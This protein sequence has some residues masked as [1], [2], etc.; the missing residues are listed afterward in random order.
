[1]GKNVNN[2]WNSPNVDDPKNIENNKAEIKTAE[3]LV[4]KKL[5]FSKVICLSSEF[6]ATV[7]KC[8]NPNWDVS[9]INTMKEVLPEE[10]FFP[11]RDKRKE[12]NDITAALAVWSL[13]QNRKRMMMIHMLD[14]LLRKKRISIQTVVKKIS[15]KKFASLYPNAQPLD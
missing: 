11:E 12:K 8:F 13:T 9:S 3:Q 10:L 2:S 7:L 6:M 1:M 5:T 4:Y 14:I 15:S